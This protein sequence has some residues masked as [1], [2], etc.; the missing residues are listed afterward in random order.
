MSLATGRPTQILSVQYV[1]GIAAIGVAAFHGSLL[2]NVSFSVGN[3]GVDAF[4]VISGFVMWLITSGRNVTMAAFFGQRIKRVVPI[5]WVVTLFL[6]LAATL[7]PNLF[8]RENPTV[9][10]VVESLL[11]IPH[12]APNGSIW[13]LL[14]QGWTLNY[15][16]FFYLL[17]GLLL[18]TSASTRLASLTFVI[19]ILTCIGRLFPFV[20]RIA[21]TD[22]SPLLLEFLAGVWLAQAWIR[23]RLPPV[24]LA[25]SMLSSGVLVLVASNWLPNVEGFRVL[26]WGIPALLILTGLVSLEKSQAIKPRLRVLKLLGDASYSIYLTH[27]LAI[28]AIT[29]M[30]ARIG[31]NIEGQAYLLAP[32]LVGAVAIGVVSYWLVEKPLAGLLRPVRFPQNIRTQ[33]P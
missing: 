9:P 17:F 28:L 12:V 27:S 3:A 4:F 29:I 11:F 32:I 24:W 22:T 1:R 18:I 5:Y 14:I 2:T 33:D 7:K 30:L 10:H 21:L 19:L 31:V 20:N 13:P 25:W 8:P 6:A 16:M 26:I 23:D 15:E